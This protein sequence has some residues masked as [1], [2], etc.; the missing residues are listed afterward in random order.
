MVRFLSFID[1]DARR[2]GSGMLLLEDRRIYVQCRSSNSSGRSHHLAGTD[3][4]KRGRRVGVAVHIW[5]LTAGAFRRG[6][7]P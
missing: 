5:L 6:V 4:V 2:R 3:I 7:A 1:D